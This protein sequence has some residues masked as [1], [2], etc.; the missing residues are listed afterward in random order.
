MKLSDRPPII[1][2]SEHDRWMCCAYLGLFRPLISQPMTD[3]WL[4]VR[5]RLS[6]SLRPWI[7]F[8][9]VGMSTLMVTNPRRRMRTSH[10]SVYVGHHQCGYHC[11]SPESLNQS[12]LSKVKITMCLYVVVYY[13][14]DFWMILMTTRMR[15][16]SSLL[17]PKFLKRS[18]IVYDSQFHGE[19]HKNYKDGSLRTVDQCTF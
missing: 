17:L 10:P 19:G 11:V 18:L 13:I 15:T 4:L 14:N 8:Q 7:P 3:P 5:D 12:N 6:A 2:L 16:L 1:V 9:T